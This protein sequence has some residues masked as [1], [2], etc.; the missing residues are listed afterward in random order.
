[1]WLPALGAALFLGAGV[2]WLATAKGPEATDADAGAAAAA[3]PAPDAGAAPK[4]H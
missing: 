1:M 4:G 2:W 3:A